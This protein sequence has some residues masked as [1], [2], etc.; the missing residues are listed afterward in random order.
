MDTGQILEDREVAGS[1]D[2]R[3]GEGSEEDPETSLP[4]SI[5]ELPKTRARAAGTAPAPALTPVGNLL[6]LGPFCQ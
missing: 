2:V 3:G 4:L 1:L 5:S 6:H